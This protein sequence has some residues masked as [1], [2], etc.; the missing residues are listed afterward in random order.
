MNHCST[1]EQK[2]ER[3]MDILRLPSCYSLIDQFSRDHQVSRQTLY[4]W[5]QET[6]QTLEDVCTYTYR[7]KPRIRRYEEQRQVPTLLIEAC[8]SYRKI[9]TYFKSLLGTPLSLAARE[10]RPIVDVHSA[11]VWAGLPR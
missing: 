1:S 9:R 7:P 5:K 6:E 2:I 8:A 4:L 11:Q 3:T 10:E